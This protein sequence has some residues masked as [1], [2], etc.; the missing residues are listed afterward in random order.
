MTK[1]IRSVKVRVA[2]FS[3]GRKI[4]EIPKSVRDNFEIGEEVL[5]KK[6]D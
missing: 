2:N 1:R 3:N 4:I 6:N 5:I